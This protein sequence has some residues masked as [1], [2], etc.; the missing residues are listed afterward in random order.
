MAFILNKLENF[1]N[2]AEA[3]RSL[4]Q[5]IVD[6]FHITVPNNVKEAVNVLVSNLIEA[7]EKDIDSLQ[8]ALNH[9]MLSN[10]SVMLEEGLLD[11]IRNKTRLAFIIMSLLVIFHSPSEAAQHGLKLVHHIK[12]EHVKRD[13]EKDTETIKHE[14]AD[15]LTKEIPQKASEIVSKA[16]EGIEKRFKDFA[17]KKVG[18]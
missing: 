9:M 12:S 7:N 1:L 11:F 13:F 8:Q 17:N 15:I 6:L 10:E 14:L 16:K 3:K 2:E 18:K 4:I 5:K